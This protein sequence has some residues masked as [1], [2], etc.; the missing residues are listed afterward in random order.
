MK[1]M[2]LHEEIIQHIDRMFRTQLYGGAPLLDDLGRLRLDDWELREDVQAEVRKR[3]AAITTDNVMALSDLEGFRRDFL[4]IFGF[5]ASGV[6][7]EVDVS[8]LG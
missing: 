3:W 6:D 5:E 8:P 2:A 1:E 7:Y 4:K